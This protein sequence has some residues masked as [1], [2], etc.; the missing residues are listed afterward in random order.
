MRTSKPCSDHDISSGVCRETNGATNEITRNCG[1]ACIGTWQNF[2]TCKANTAGVWK[3][4]AYYR[5]SQNPAG[6]GRLCEF[7]DGAQKIVDCVIRWD[8]PASS[9]MRAYFPDSGDKWNV[10]CNK[11]KRFSW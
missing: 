6:G 8:L 1:T 5:I 9:P 4:K 3:A 10:C 11:V 7:T 2:K